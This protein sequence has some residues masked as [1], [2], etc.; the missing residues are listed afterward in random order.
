MA[1]KHPTHRAYCC[2]CYTSTLLEGSKRDCAR[3]A[4]GHMNAYGHST[5]ILELSARQVIK[6]IKPTSAH[7]GA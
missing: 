3:A 5:G 7:K 1:S 4:T 6:Q 2:I